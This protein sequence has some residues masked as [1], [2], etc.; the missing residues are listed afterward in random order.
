M[1]LSDWMQGYSTLKTVYLLKRSVDPLV[2]HLILCENVKETLLK[3][4]STIV[5]RQLSH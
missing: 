4:S 5:R 1:W 2:P 3:Y